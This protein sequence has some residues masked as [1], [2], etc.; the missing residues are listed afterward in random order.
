MKRRAL[1]IEIV[2][3]LFVLL[4]LYA[5]GSKLIQY[6]EFVGQMG[7]SF[8]VSAYAP[9]L[10][11]LVPVIE[12]AISILLLI[13]RFR[14]YGLYGSFFIMFL[15]TLYILVILN[16]APEVPCSCGGILSNMGWKPHLLFNVVFTILAVISIF[17]HNKEFVSFR[18]NPSVT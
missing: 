16:F 17:I 2:I 8:L 6:K 11:W 14:L 13:P 3:F 5:A 1:F 12:I 18:N 9:I 4:F 15:F 10:A 7:K